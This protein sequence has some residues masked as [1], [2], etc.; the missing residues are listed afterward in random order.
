MIIAL[1]LVVFA[2]CVAFVFNEG[3]WG[4]AITFVNVLLAAVLATNLF[5]PLANWLESMMPGFTYFW[6]FV[7]LWLAFA[8][9]LVLLRLTTD[10]ISRHRVK[11]KKPVD[12]GGG[13]FFAIWTGW[14]MVQFTLFSLHLA[15]LSRNFMG[16]QEKPETHMFVFDLAPDRNWL[17]FMHAQSSGGALARTPPPTDPNAFVFDPQ[18]EFIMKYAARRKQFESQPLQVK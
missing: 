7:A 15:P 13:V 17:S 16:F 4:A 6:D 1:L 5:E 12:I 14:L 11:F 10:L 9:C 18:G 3:M 2:V 8:L